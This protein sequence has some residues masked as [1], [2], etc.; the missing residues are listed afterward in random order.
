MPL[1]FFFLKSAASL[2]SEA[3]LLLFHMTFESSA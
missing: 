1:R 3:A 2:I